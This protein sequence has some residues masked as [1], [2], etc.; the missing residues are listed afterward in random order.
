MVLS[1]LMSGVEYHQLKKGK[2]VSLDEFKEFVEE[3]ANRVD[4]SS[5]VYSILGDKFLDLVK[6]RT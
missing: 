3:E 1:Y 6:G 4:H 5:Y 2:Q